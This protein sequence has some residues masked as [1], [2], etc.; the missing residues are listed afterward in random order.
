MNVTTPCLI[1]S[2]GKEEG[3]KILKENV[4]KDEKKSCLVRK[5]RRRKRIL[6]PVELNII[7]PRMRDFRGQIITLSSEKLSVRYKYF[8]NLIFK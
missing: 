3:G 7:S 8:F 4:E 1:E 5:Q 2:E 6:I